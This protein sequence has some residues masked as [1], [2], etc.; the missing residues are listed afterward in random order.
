MS[1]HPYQILQLEGRKNAI[2]IELNERLRRRREELQSSIEAL[3]EP[4]DGDSSSA[5]DLDARTRE[6][7]V[8][9]NSIQSLTKKAQG[10]LLARRLH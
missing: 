5:N 7:R 1:L 6:L 3:G 8:L 2:E 10:K 4:E 9:N